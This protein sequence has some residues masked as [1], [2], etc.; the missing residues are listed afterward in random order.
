MVRE[1]EIKKEPQLPT[2]QKR[3]CALLQGSKTTLAFVVSP[4]HPTTLSISGGD[5]VAVQAM[6]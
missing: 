5:G 1:K 3:Q 4:N 6:S 2:K